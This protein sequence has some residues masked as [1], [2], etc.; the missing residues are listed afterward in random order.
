[1]TDADDLLFISEGGKVVR[2]HARDVSRIGRNTQG[3]RLVR[4]KEGDSL[5]AVSVAPFVEGAAE[6][7]PDGD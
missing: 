5:A 1:V 2:T 3:V 6:A 4:L 7:M